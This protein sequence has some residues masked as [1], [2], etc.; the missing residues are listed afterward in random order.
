[1]YKVALAVVLS[2]FSTS[3]FCK[4]NY[5]L[6]LSLKQD[7][8]NELQE[9]TQFSSGPYAIEYS[10]GDKRLVIGLPYND[11]RETKIQEKMIRKIEDLH[12]DITLEQSKIQ[13]SVKETLVHLKS[14]DYSLIDLAYYQTIEIL[15]QHYGPRMT[16][17]NE[18]IANAKILINKINQ[19]QDFESAKPFTLENFEKWFQT[20]TDLPFTIQNVQNGD[21]VAPMGVKGTTYLQAFSSRM[22][23]VQDNYFLQK[24]ANTL[25]QQKYKTIAVL[26]AHSKF[27]TEGR[28]LTKMMGSEPNIFFKAK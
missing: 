24:L 2:I 14:Y 27:A 3:A 11:S 28:V 19:N 7:W 20:K 16:N 5:Q 15:N 12:P 17:Q 1:M 21:L 13:P 4:N 10:N 25:N 26:I 8:S 22:D 18:L 23:E 6:D 9:K